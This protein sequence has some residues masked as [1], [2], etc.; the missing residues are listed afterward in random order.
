MAYYGF[1]PAEQ[2]IQVGDNTI[3]SAD[4]VDGVIVNADINASAA[5][6]LSKTQLVAGTGITLATNTLNVDAAQTQITSVGTI[7]T[8]VWQGT[9]V[10]S[11]YLDA[12]TAHLSGTQTFSGAKTFSSAVNVALSDASVSPSSDADDLVVENN[13]ACGITIASAANSVGSLRFADSGASHAGMLYYSHA[14]NFMKFYTDATE[15]MIINNAGL[16]GI[17]TSDPGAVLETTGSIDD[18]WA[19]RFENTHSG[20]YGLMAKI[21]GASVNEYALQI[22]SGSTHLFKVM[23]NGV[24]TW[25]S[26][27][28]A[29]SFEEYADGAVLWLDG[30]NGDMAGGDYWGL[31]AINGGGSFAIDRA[32]TPKMTITTAGD[33]TFTG[34]L[35]TT[36][37]SASYPAYSFS[38]SNTGMYLGAADTLRIATGGAER[39]EITNTQTKISGNFVTTGA[40]EQR[41]SG[42]AKFIRKVH[43]ADG[44]FSGDLIIYCSAT[45][46]K[47][48]IY[49]IT[50]SGHSG[51]GHWH[52]MFYWNSSASDHS[53]SIEDY[54]GDVDNLVLGAYSGG[55]GNQGF[56]LQ[57]NL[58]GITHP[59]IIVEL[60]AGGGD[61]IPESDISI[62]LS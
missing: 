29:M 59:V 16:V 33:A 32:G 36:D 48:V 10:A 60:T 27:S 57:A 35:Y 41:S 13:G 19:G 3:V 15:R 45:S 9:A 38:D 47:S 14:S 40:I 25:K 26:G 53:R 11:A 20:G 6:A 56:K 52:G 44:T 5:I 46:W 50:I 12:D 37:G 21:A 54:N 23:G 17:G 58:T 42:S 1:K 2:A 43:Q 34:R 55:S 31:R 18:N 7:G 51:S 4:I 30:V 8:G 61:T 39:L 49:D 28:A 22:R 24:S 62:N